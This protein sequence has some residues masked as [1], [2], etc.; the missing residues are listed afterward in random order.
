M[1]LS[2]S[3]LHPWGRGGFISHNK[4]MM[5]MKTQGYSFPEVPMFRQSEIVGLA[6]SQEIEAKARERRTS[7]GELSRFAIPPSDDK[8]VQRRR[9]PGLLL[10]GRRQ[11]TTGF[12]V[13]E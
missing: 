13:D 6:S 8:R 5:A 4:G 12:P 9:W 7:R 11:N 3:A 2:A 1:N 10:C